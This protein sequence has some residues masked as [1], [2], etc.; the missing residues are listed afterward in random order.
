MEELSY[1][2]AQSQRARSNSIRRRPQGRLLMLSALES[3]VTIPAYHVDLLRCS[4]DSVSVEGDGS[5][6]SAGDR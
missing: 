6:R 3:Y 2:S 4:D 5:P 1:L